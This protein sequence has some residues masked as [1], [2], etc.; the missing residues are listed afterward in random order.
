MSEIPNK[1][2]PSIYECGPQSFY[3]LFLA[4]YL[5]PKLVLSKF[6]APSPPHLLEHPLEQH[7]MDSLQLHA[8]QC[9]QQDPQNHLQSPPL[10]LY[11]PYGHKIQYYFLRLLCIQ[12]G[13]LEYFLQFLQQV[14]GDYPQL[15]IR[16]FQH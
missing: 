4:V 14:L 7:T 3:Q 12:S 2:P 13:A 10:L 1:F 9:F 5:T 6:H 15:L 16:L 11:G 8:L